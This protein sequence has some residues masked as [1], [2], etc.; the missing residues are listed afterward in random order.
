MMAA[1]VHPRASPTL[2]LGAGSSEGSCLPP[3]GAVQ[4]TV[5]P[6]TLQL[7]EPCREDIQPTLQERQ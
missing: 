5:P 1:K 6:N 3:Q 7:G 4:K 2:T